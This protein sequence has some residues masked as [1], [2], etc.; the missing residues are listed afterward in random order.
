MSLLRCPFLARQPMS[1][2]R[3][4]SAYMMN[5]ARNCPIMSKVLSSLHPTSAQ[6]HTSGVKATD[7]GSRDGGA[8]FEKCPFLVDSGLKIQ[9]PNEEVLKDILIEKED[10]GMFQVAEDK[11]AAFQ[12][13]AKKCPFSSKPVADSKDVPKQPGNSFGYESFF[14]KK[15]FEKKQDQSYRVFNK[16]N[17][18]AKKFPYGQ[19]YSHG[20]NG[21][22]ISV[23]CSNDYLGIG[24]HPKVMEAVRETMDEYGVGAGGT[25]NISGNSKFHG[26][27]EERLAKLHQKEAGLVFTSCYVANDTTLF[28]LGKLLP[29]CHIFSDAGNHASMIQGIRN[30]GAKKHVFRHNDPAHLEELLRKVDPDLPKIVA[31]ETVH[32][33]DGSICP[34]EEL[35]DVAHKYGALTFVDEVHAV[36]MYGA[37]GAGV[38]EERQL[39]DRMDIITGTLGKAFGLIG[40]YIVG[41]AKLVDT[42]RSYGSGFIFTTSL[43]PMIVR[44]A[45][46]SIDVLAGED[47]V[48]LRKAHQKNAKM[49]RNR[50]I[51]A[52]IPVIYAPSHIIPVHVGDPEKCTQVSNDLMKQ[53]NIYVQ[54]INY[55]TV[56]RGEER[57]RIAPTPH[58]TP[59]M[60]D[61]FVEALVQIWQANDLPFVWPVCNNSCGCQAQCDTAKQEG[62]ISEH[63]A[64]PLVGTA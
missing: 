53:Y 45:I 29:G 20:K 24:H 62:L 33:M 31:F 23:W 59:E 34:L 14:D 25:R 1:V 12:E 44:G 61:E 43:P 32:S 21:D 27:L 58:H 6:M 22:E 19:S 5:F 60:M 57:L 18:L 48:R 26:M 64:L 40:G 49:L 35:C 8:N 47:G 13:N 50:I 10:Q 4:K 17:R 39:L 2:L 46:T 11:P 55:P 54:A 7:S 28:T 41:S 36:G 16:V 42:V 9:K 37:H 63:Y 51:Q 15:I 30:S 3:T 38:G 56:A 52:G